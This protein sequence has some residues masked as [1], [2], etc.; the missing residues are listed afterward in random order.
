MI[1]LRVRM[2]GVHG[3]S[4]EAITATLEWP[5][6]KALCVPPWHTLARIGGVAGADDLVRFVSCDNRSHTGVTCASSCPVVNAV[7]I[8]LVAEVSPH[9][10]FCLRAVIRSVYVGR[11]D[12]S[13]SPVNALPNT[14]RGKCGL[15]WLCASSP[16]LSVASVQPRCACA[17]ARCVRAPVCLCMCVCA[18]VLACMCLC[19]CARV[20]VCACVCL[21]VCV[22]E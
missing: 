5:E 4:I 6:L 12:V 18:Y 9:C 16:L 22:L 11:R 7:G 8:K 3:G 14:W 20:C 15:I 2:F 13:G 10:P 21:C 17:C 19:V 1:V